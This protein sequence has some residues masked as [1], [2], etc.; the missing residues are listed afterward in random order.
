MP[1]KAKAGTQVAS[2][3]DCS[4]ART[5]DTGSSAFAD[6]DSRARRTY[7]ATRSPLRAFAERPSAPRP[8]A[9]GADRLRDGV[10]AWRAVS[11]AHRGHR[12]HPM[13]SRIRTDDL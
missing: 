1:A 4:T 9:L 5:E 7:E 6:D 11:A 13:P 2:A 10:R 12:C 3:I 8:C